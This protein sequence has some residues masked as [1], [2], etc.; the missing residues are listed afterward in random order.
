M[1]QLPVFIQ[2]EFPGIGVAKA[3]AKLDTGAFTGTLHCSSIFVRFNRLFFRPYKSQS[4]YVS[5]CWRTKRVVW[6]NGQSSELYVIDTEVVIDDIS[7]TIAIGLSNR[8][9]LKYPVIIG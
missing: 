1:K 4:M 3:K 6:G 8:K 5:D 9:G 7:Y 2:V